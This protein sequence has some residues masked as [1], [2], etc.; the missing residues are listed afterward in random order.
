MTQCKCKISFNF[1]PLF[2]RIWP[3]KFY[4]NCD[5]VMFAI[6]YIK[7]IIRLVLNLYS[8]KQVKYLFIQC[9]FCPLP[10]VWFASV[11]QADAAAGSD[12]SGSS[13]S[14][15]S[16]SGWEHSWTWICGRH[17]PSHQWV[18]LVLYLPFSK[19][20]TLIVFHDCLS[21]AFWIIITLW[22]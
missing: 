15:G 7:T 16:S 17:C 12:S 11:P 19:C 1:L 22:Q 6:E 13:C 21:K 3:N 10:G 14:P 20:V 4:S 9:L 8:M 2:K 18:F 5:L